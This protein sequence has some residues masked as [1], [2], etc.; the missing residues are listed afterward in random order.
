MLHGFGSSADVWF[1]YEDSLGNYFSNLD[2]D[3]WALNLSNAVSGNIITLAH[4]ELLT[5]L[6]FI[7]RKKQQSVVLVAHS[8]GGIISRVLTSPHFSHPYKLDRTNEILKGIALLTVPNHGVGSTDLSKIEETVNFFRRMFKSD[9]QDFKPTAPDF[10][11]GFAQL[12]LKSQLLSKLNQP[13]PLNPNIK[14]LNAVGIYDR[15]V[16]LTSAC[17]EAEEIQNI[18]YFN[19]QEFPCDHMVFPFSGILKKLTNAIP[20]GTSATLSSLETKIKIYPAIHRYDKVGH[21]I[22]EKLIKKTQ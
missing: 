14:W 13:L 18:P 6:D 19:Q 3:C 21:W 20:E 2:C 7:Y 9:N 15:V 4:E 17:F 12:S 16:P 1:R 8:M 22:N 11:L 5:S 10:G